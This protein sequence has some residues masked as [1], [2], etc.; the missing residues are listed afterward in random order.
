[1]KNKRILITGG[2]GS[3]G[4]ALTERFIKAGASLT[5]FSRDEKK[6]YDM[7]KIYPDCRYIVG[8]I[9]DY[10]AVR[11][12]VRDIDIVIHGAS[13]KYVNIGEIQPAEYVTTNVIGTLNVINAVLD[14]KTVENCV[15]ISSDKA[16]MP[17]NTYGFTKAILERTILEANQRQGSKGNTVFNIARYGN[18]IGTRGSV[19]LFWQ[20]RRDA[21]LTIPITNPDM[22]RFFFTIEE[23]VDLIVYCL[24]SKPGLIISKAM[25]GVTVGKL[26]EIMKGECKTEIIGE[27]LGEKHDEM[28]MTSEEMMKTYEDSG[29]FVFD[30]LTLPKPNENYPNGYSSQ[31]APVITEEQLKIILKEYL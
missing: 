9:R 4:Q 15:G 30:P 1:M 26:A 19:V 21:G 25:R 5:I 28:L 13:L 7:K 27:R 29:M 17:I 6:Q 23:A 24:N 12:A 11:D 14:E 10:H 16:C 20:E 2:T 18:V 3:L 31:D 8:D 22:T